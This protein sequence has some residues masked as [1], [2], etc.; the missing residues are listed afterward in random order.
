MLQQ[1]TEEQIQERQEL[2]FTILDQFIEENYDVD[3]DYVMTEEDAYITSILMDYFE[4]NFKYPTLKES[5]L[6]AI[7]GY[8]INTPLY[9]E[10]YDV[11]LDESIGTFVAGARYGIKGFLAN[12]AKQKATSQAQQAKEKST[13]MG[14]KAKSAADAARTAP[15]G[16]NPL[17]RAKYAFAVNKSKTVQDRA[18]KAKEA[19]KT[20]ETKRKSA[21]ATAGNVEGRRGVLAKRI[22]TGVENVKNKVKTAINTGASKV[23]GFLGKVAG[24]FA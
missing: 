4:E 15:V 1:L 14:V 12:R 16:K 11:L 20:A 8:D 9:E 5:A 18:A 10:L 13:Q 21:S 6:E 2:F 17:E 24:R 23:G 22:D 19:Y 3:E 7:T